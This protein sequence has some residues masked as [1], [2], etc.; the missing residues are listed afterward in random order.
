[1]SIFLFVVLA[2]W[3]LMLQTR[4]ATKC[5]HEELRQR[6]GRTEKMFHMASG[7]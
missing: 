4:Q 6:G 7:I 3:G 5:G 1:M 2:K